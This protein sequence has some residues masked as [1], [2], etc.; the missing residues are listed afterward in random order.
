MTNSPPFTGLNSATPLD[1]AM[2][3]VEERLHPIPVPHR[4]KRPI[5][6]GWPDLRLTLADIPKY[7]SSAPKNIGIILG[8]ETGIA[9]VDCDTIEAVIAARLFLPKTGMVFGRASKRASHY[10]YR[11]DPPLPIA[12]FE[13]PVDHQMLVELRCRKKNGG[14]GFQTV[15]PPSVHESGEKIE[16]EPGGDGHPANTD[17]GELHAA[18]RRI[19]A[20]TTLARHWPE[21]GRHIAMLALAGALWRAGFSLDDAKIFCRAVY[22]AVPTHD[23]AAVSRSDR[24]VED[25]YKRG[26]ASLELGEE[27]K[28]TGWPTLGKIVGEKVVGCAMAWLDSSATSDARAASEPGPPE[29]PLPTSKPPEPEYQASGPV[30]PHSDGNSTTN[31]YPYELKHGGIVRVKETK[32]GSEEIRLTNFAASI[33]DDIAEDDGVETKRHLQIQAAVGGRTTSFMVPAPKFHQMDWPIEHHGPQAI[34]FP[35][36]KEWARTGIQILSNNIERTTIYTHSGWRKLGDRWV[37]LHGTGAI[38]PTGAVDGIN[39]HLSGALSH[40]GLVLPTT[41]AEMKIAINASLHL[42]DAAPDHIT[43]PLIASTYRACIK[44][45]DFALWFGGPTGVFKSELA[46]LAQQHYGAGMDARHLPANFASTGNALEMVAFYAKDALLVIDDFAPHGS[47][48]DVAR[49]HGAAERILRAAGN[50]QGRG[51]LTSDTKLRDAK[52]PRGLILVTGED[53]PRGQSIRGRI[54]IVEVGPGDVKTAILTENQRD[55][56]QGL[57]AKAM[58]GFIKHLAVTYDQGQVQFQAAVL[59][60]RARS[61]KVHSR[62][63]GMVADLQCGFECFLNFAVAVGAITEGQRC[64][65]TERCW[66]ALNHVARA[67]REPQGA[68]EPARRFITVLTAALAA[69]KAHVAGMKGGAPAEDEVAWGWRWED[70]G[71]DVKRV[72]KGTCIGWVDG[73]NLYLEPTAAYAA[74]QE[75]VRSAGEPLAVSEISLNKRLNEKGLLATVDTKRG[76]LTVRRTIQ[77]VNRKVLHLSAAVFLDDVG[78]RSQDVGGLSGNSEEPDI[79]SGNHIKPLQRNVG[80]VGQNPVEEGLGEFEEI[81]DAILGQMEVVDV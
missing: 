66:V 49:Y 70:A 25:T 31:T 78:F 28:V 53:V 30:P 71:R 39:V 68:S 52:A 37:Y 69:G 72:A 77:G 80:I 59:E 61:T 5:L 79:D 74:V 60:A 76:T 1:A 8:D 13:D 35:N 43:F 75:F 15:V 11:C 47:M 64:G 10:F 73:P 62:T 58:A 50:S 17:G 19:A 9:D 67:Q 34:V 26:T 48:Q 21:K 54:L 38:G 2:R 46:A 40:F 56:A 65:L 3:Y 81:E 23:P 6:D 32:D 57:Y 18:V 33:T 7:F 51:R 4:T 24:E 14:T 12:Q 22:L 36:Q 29:I 45:A 27:A 20:A 63:P 55:A 42:I 41:E 44:T 16:F